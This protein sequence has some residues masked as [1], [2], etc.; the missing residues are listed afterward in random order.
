LGHCP[1]AFRFDPESVSPWPGGGMEQRQVD[2]FSP[3]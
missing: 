1:M 2:A 3:P